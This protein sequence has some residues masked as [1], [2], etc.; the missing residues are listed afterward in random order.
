VLSTEYLLTSRE[1]QRAM[2]KYIA[3]GGAHFVEHDL[4]R[5]VGSDSDTLEEAQA[6]LGHKTSQITSRVYRAKPVEVE[7]LKR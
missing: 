2:R 6:R 3:A 7:V 4:R 1:G 5:K